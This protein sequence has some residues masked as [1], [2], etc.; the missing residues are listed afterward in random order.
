MDGGK[1]DYMEVFRVI[2]VGCYCGLVQKNNS[3]GFKK[4][5]DFR[6]FGRLGFFD[7]WKDGVVIYKM[8]EVQLDILG[9]ML[10]RYLMKMLSRIIRVW[11]NWD[12]FCMWELLEQ[13]LCVKFRDRTRFL[14]E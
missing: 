1:E 9:W 10:I 11:R 8:W 13:S 4:L 7:S 5:F 2:Q 14:W 6:L 3:V 12:W